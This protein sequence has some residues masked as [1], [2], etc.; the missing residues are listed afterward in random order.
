MKK[1]VPVEEA[2]GMVLPHDITEIVKDE[3]KGRAFKK[4]HIIREEDIEHL[5]RLGK[6][7]IYVLKLGP[8]EIHENEAAEILARALSGPGSML[9]AEP[10]EGKIAINAKCDGLLKVNEEALYRFNLLG[11]VMCS[12]LQ[13]NT[14]VKK[15]ENIAATRLIPL[16]SER[17]VVEEAAA[18]AKNANSIISVKELR[19]AKAGLIITGNE[20]FH[21]RIEDKFE[22]V[23]RNKLAKIGSEVISVT[24]APDDIEI[25]GKAITDAIVGGA[26]L[27]ITSGGMSVDPDDVTRMGIEHAGATDCFYGTPVLPGAMFLSGKIGD[28]PVL[29]L[30]ACGMF[31]NITVFDL[32]LP[33]ILSGESIGREE[34]ARMGHGGLCRNCKRCQYPVCNFGK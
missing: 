11:V 13:T 12:T 3:F 15:G 28:I 26:D 5:K 31:H 2:V 20:V 9:S 18:I 16:V 32:I 27:I 22:Q 34:F 8:D 4:G 17:A 29:G 25:I 10:V 21:G 7:H 24:F 6:E 30:P 14:P 1:I 33:R 19:K 23:L